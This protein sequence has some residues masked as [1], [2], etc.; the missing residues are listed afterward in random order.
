MIIVML[1]CFASFSYSQEDP[2]TFLSFKKR[3]TLKECI[4]ISIQNHP[5]VKI[6]Q[7]DKKIAL[8]RYRLA[9]ASSKILVNGEIKTQEFLT[10]NSSGSGIDVPGETTS[11]GIFAG[12]TATYTVY[13][14]T[15]KRNQEITRYGLDLSKLQSQQQLNVVVMN[16][17]RSYYNY[18]MADEILKL[19]EEILTKFSEKLKLA[20]MLFNSGQ[21]PILDVSRADVSFSESQLEYEKA[22]NIK[23]MLKTQLF[24]SMGLDEPTHEF[25]LEN[26]PELPELKY[27]LEDMYK[28]GEIYYPEIIIVQMQK[29]IKKMQIDVE[30]AKRYPT[31][32]FLL[33]LSYQNRSLYYNNHFG[34]LIPGKW[35][36]AI[37][38]AIMA[39]LPIYDGGAITSMVDAAS[40]EYNKTVFHEREVV[41][42]MRNEIRTNF[43][44]LGEL[45]KQI[46]MSQLV[47]IN[48]E[49]HYRLAQKS[50]ESG[51]G[52]QLE[53]QDAQVSVINAQI[54]F[55]S[56]KYSYLLTLAKLSSMVGLGEDYLCKGK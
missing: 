1:T 23:R 52:S 36:P 6:S 47:I 39:K 5:D 20:K 45:L 37:N 44:S 24:S 30:K 53:M 8:S 31:V 25:V 33:S 56:A 38:G 51:G 50:Y 49:K 46:K 29:K 40:S 41:L 15:R 10:E 2:D 11:I 26:F 28:L 18:Q 42:K 13:D 35:E 3:T 43:D 48:A 34:E 27:S 54:G 17:K 19:R 55:I 22:R 7:E 14:A 21:R 9:I 32:S 4:E 12:F 16:L